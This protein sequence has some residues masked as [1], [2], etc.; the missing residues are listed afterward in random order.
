MIRTLRFFLRYYNPANSR[1]I[2]YYATQQNF[3]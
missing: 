3:T 1:P 2:G